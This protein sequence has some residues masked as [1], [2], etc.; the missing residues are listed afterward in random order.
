MIRNGVIPDVLTHNYLLNGLCKT[1]ELEKANWLVSEMLYC[2]TSPNCA[3]YNTLMKGYCLINNVDRAL[4]VFSTMANSGVTP[5]RVSCNILVHA[6]CKKG[7]LED[8][9]KLLKEILDEN[10]DKGRSNLITST[11]LMDGHFKNGDTRIRLYLSLFIWN[12]IID[13]Y[14]RSGDIQNALSIR[15]QMVAFGVLP[16]VFTY[17]ALIRA[18]TKRGKIVEAHSLKKEMLV[19]GLSPDLVTYNLLLGAACYVGHIQSALQ[20]HDE[21]LRTG[22]DPDIITY[23]ELIKEKAC[24][25]C[26]EGEGH[27]SGSPTQSYPQLIQLIEFV[28]H[29]LNFKSYDGGSFLLFQWFRLIAGN[30]LV[31]IFDYIVAS[32]FFAKTM[33]KIKIRINIICVVLCCVVSGFRR[34]GRLVARVALQSDD[35]ELV[36]VNDPFITIDYMNFCDFVVFML[37]A[38]MEFCAVWTYMF[39]Y[40]SVHNQWKKNE[41]KVKDSKTLLFGDKPVAVFGSRNPEEILWGEVGAEY[42]VESMGVFTDKDKAAAHLKVCLNLLLS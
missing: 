3:T 15:D 21:I 18:H 19:N 38:W 35:V 20:L 25:F 12:S 40:D 39:K 26:T 13:G 28:K 23:T 31:A 33:G 42:V 27:T 17:N 10:C 7:L 8:A 2:G 14:G 5:N 37:F 1:G 9:R 22:Y 29:G 32:N 16:N 41:L 24:G 34:I 4:D 11:I 36:A 30:I 6:L